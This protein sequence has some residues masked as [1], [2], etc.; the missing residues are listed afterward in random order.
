VAVGLGVEVGSGVKVG[1]DVAV[2][3]GVSVAVGSRVR[4]GSGGAPNEQAR[5]ARTMVRKDRT[6][7]IERVF[8]MY[9]LLG[10]VPWGFPLY[11]LR[12]MVRPVG[13][14][15]VN[16]SGLEVAKFGHLVKDSQ[17]EFVFTIIY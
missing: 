4:V 12:N 11:T 13:C 5:D 6:T 1:S 14:D 7:R 15:V 9:I 3:S 8:D 10:M 17:T 2:G 16:E